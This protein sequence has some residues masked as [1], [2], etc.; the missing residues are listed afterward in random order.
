MNIAIY[1]RKSRFTGAGES[2][3]NQV[4]MCTEYCLRHFGDGCSFQVYEDEGYSA[5]NTDRPMFQK[6]MA[7]IKKKT[8]HVLV[9]YRLDRISRSVS[10]F[11]AILEQL[12]AKG[13]EFVSIRES[14]DT[15]TPMGRAMIYIA[16][17]FAQ[18]E[19]ETIA[20]RVKDNKYMLAHTGR[21]QGGFAPLGYK[22]RKV[23][24][25]DNDRK[26][27]SFFVLE[28][29]PKTCELVQMI[30]DLY[31]KLG[32]LHQVESY[33]QVNRITSPRGKEYTV[34][35]IR[36]ILKNPAYGT[37]TPETYAFLKSEGVSI[38]SG[39]EEWDGTK[40]L[41]SYSR[42]GS[43][44]GGTRTRNSMDGWIVAIGYHESVI[45]GDTWL[46]VQQQMQANRDRYPHWVA[47]ELALLSGMIRCKKC[48]S[49]M[50]IQGNRCTAD[51]KKNYYYRC[52]LKKSSKGTLCDIKNISGPSYDAAISDQVSKLMRELE[53]LMKQDMRRRKSKKSSAQKEIAL[54]ESEISKNDTAIKNLVIKM[55]ASPDPEIDEYIRKT[56]SSLSQDNAALKEKLVI[57][58]EKGAEASGEDDVNLMFQH[59]Q[60]FNRLFGTADLKEKRRLLKNVV[61]RIVWDGKQSS[62]DLFA[63]DFFKVL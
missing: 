14:F 63:S 19:R 47:G 12:Q 58:S 2:I 53:V 40:G 1:S 31:L 33:L 10:D 28:K 55:S 48:G 44:A 46:K 29:D 8:I 22:T 34:Q 13:I 41:V 7:D 21:W 59:V 39:I 43:N 16:S 51:G 18:L 27:R 52:Q 24:Y 50:L 36:Q 38:S 54:I 35:T 42:Y 6:M 25:T 37:N 3:E 9:C 11:S 49:P 61:R 45:P 15:S 30:F 20:E 57:L 26:N 17:V 23:V 62:I 60:E 4:E 32:S 5:K 56:I